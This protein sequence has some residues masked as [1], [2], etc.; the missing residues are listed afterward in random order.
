MQI[1]IK[2]PSCSADS[3]FFTVKKGFQGPFRCWKCKSL[4]TLKVNKDG[5]TELLEPL[6]QEDFEKQKA[7]KEA[8][9]KKAR[10]KTA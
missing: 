5:D 4:F 2:C 6:S 10:E 3:S 9:R 8:R 7:D 1:T